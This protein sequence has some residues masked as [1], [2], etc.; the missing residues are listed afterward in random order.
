MT[1]NQEGLD[2]NTQETS[3]G[4]QEF[5]KGE[6]TEQLSEQGKQDGYVSK[7]D[8]DALVSEL[9]GLQGKMDKDASAI[10]KRVTSSVRETME[11][12]GVKLDP[13][14]ENELRFMEMQ[15][16]LASLKVQAPAKSEPETPVEIAEVF[17]ALEIDEP[18]A[19]QMRLAMKHANNPFKLASELTKRN[20]SKPNPDPS[21]AVTP[22]NVRGA[23]TANV[24]MLINEF[25]KLGGMHFDEILGSGKTVRQRRA[26]ISKELEALDK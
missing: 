20:L 4:K 15:E 16:E 1:E 8:F 6:G 5:S 2:P 25:D 17:K 7:A 23:P 14:M 13:A 12:L 26:E 24:D 10:E 11:R 22:A 9:R 3:G 19:E 21:S 18:D